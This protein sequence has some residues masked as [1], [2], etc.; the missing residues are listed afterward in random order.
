[1]SGFAARTSA[2]T[3]VHDP[4]LVQAVVVGDTA[5]VSVDV[6]GLHEEDCATIR[7]RCPLPEDRVVVHATHTHGGPVSMRGRLGHPRD[8]L[9]WDRVV[10][11]C[12]DAVAEARRTQVP[13]TIRAGYAP[14][15]GVA[16]N[17][18]RPGGPVDHALPVV[19]LEREGGAALATVVSYAC[20]PVVLGA[21]NTLITADYPG[22]LRRRVG[23]A[24]GAPVLFLTGCA[25]DAN[26]GHTAA[27]SISTT[28][29][30]D[31]TFKECE[32]VGTVI[33]DAVLRAELGRS[34]GHVDARS[35]DV[36]LAYDVAGYDALGSDLAT[37]RAQRRTADP[38]TVALLTTWIDW[39]ARQHE[40]A[41]E[42]C[43]VRVTVLRW[44]PAVVV[45]LPGEPFAA[46]AHAAREAV[47]RTSPGVVALV[48]GYSNG[49]PGYLPPREEY[50]AG[51]Y[52][53]T[54]AH[55]YYGSPGPFMPGSL[56]LLLGSVERLLA[57]TSP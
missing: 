24:T 25:G 42:P 50:D 37:W 1:M 5:V 27:A 29:T 47:E 48:A 57:E 16:R 8:E 41:P 44:G 45:T 28:P 43:P 21:D 30:P 7:A 33:A 49:C 4:L 53:V 10:D 46:A 9:W 18:R 55:R 54:D 15:P 40:P 13:V 22:V 23:E 14:A 56:E 51:G 17:R 20:H 35:S 2:A 34:T 3:G 19:R 52:E 38:A 31:R 32:R 12:A 11:A 36:A 39:A 6:I 26:T